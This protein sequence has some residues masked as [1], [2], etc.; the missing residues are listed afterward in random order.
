V[1]GEK[2]HNLECCLRSVDDRLKRK[3]K[4]RQSKK[5]SLRE[6]N[7]NNGEGRDKEKMNTRMREVLV[8]GGNGHS[9]VISLDQSGFDKREIMGGKKET[10]PSIVREGQL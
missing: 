7:K 4:R 3:W 8:R 6:E 10:D 9:Q 1:G 5:N 2:E